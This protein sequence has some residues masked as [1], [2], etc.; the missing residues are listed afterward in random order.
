MCPVHD[1]R[2]YLDLL[3]KTAGD[4]CEFMHMALCVTELSTRR[5]QQQQP[6]TQ[7][8]L[9][10][11]TSAAAAYLEYDSFAKVLLP[12]G[13]T[14]PRALRETIHGI[15]GKTMTDRIRKLDFAFHHGENQILYLLKWQQVVLIEMFEMKTSVNAPKNSTGIL[16]NN[17]CETRSGHLLNRGGHWVVAEG[18]YRVTD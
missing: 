10:Q 16:T 11:C 1:V 12:T 8:R 18:S 13:S 9:R 17:V 2:T 4:P 7:S 15:V 14:S 6:T 5:R 3:T